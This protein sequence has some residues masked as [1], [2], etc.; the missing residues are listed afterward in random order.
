MNSSE[1]FRTPFN[2]DLYEAL[3]NR[4]S[5]DK[6]TDYLSKFYINFVSNDNISV[7]MKAIQNN[8]SGEF[9]DKII[10]LCDEKIFQIVDDNNR[11]C[12]DYCLIKIDNCLIKE[13]SEDIESVIE[14]L[15]KQ[16]CDF[17]LNYFFDAIALL[18]HNLL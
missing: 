12:L 18:P 1:K 11:T 13:N 3:V 4:V 17:K 10:Y 16:N 8:Y 6:L 7:L 14:N 2:N 15:L 5:E 9:I